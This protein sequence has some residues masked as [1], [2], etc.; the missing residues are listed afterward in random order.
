MAAFVGQLIALG[1]R[2][3]FQITDILIM[4]EMLVEI[5]LDKENVLLLVVWAK[6]IL[7]NVFWNG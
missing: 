4:G 2:R 6:M 3:R 5:M 7:E 1:K